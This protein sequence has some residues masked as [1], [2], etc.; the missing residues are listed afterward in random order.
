[1]IYIKSLDYNLD[2]NQFVK[3]LN[4]I[5]SEIT[6]QNIVDYD[7]VNLEDK[8]AQIYHKFTSTAPTI[9]LQL[10]EYEIYVNIS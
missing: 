2:E 1:M 9:V 6:F 10:L 5:N 3:D 8:T 4:V 7:F